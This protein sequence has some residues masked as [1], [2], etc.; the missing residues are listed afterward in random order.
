VRSTGFSRRTRRHAAARK[1][2]PPPLLLAN[3][4]DYAPGVSQH[5][6]TFACNFARSG[7]LPRTQIRIMGKHV[8]VALLVAWLLAGCKSKKDALPVVIDDI[9]SLDAVRHSC[10]SGSTLNYGLCTKTPE[11]IVDNFDNQV[12]LAF[13][14][15]PS[16]RGVVI[17]HF[18]GPWTDPLA[19]MPSW[20]L[21]LNFNEDEREASWMIGTGSSHDHNTL[22]GEGSPK[23]LAKEVCDIVRAAG[24]AV[25]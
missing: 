1:A 10:R 19:K 22:S 20:W 18:Y 8:C 11:Q 13:A 15:E 2:G 7:P 12:N 3:T 24:A 5:L 14:T 17:R 9:W 21:M 6:L 23:Q 25:H 16:C 4:L